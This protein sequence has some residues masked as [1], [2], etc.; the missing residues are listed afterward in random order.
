MEA[1]RFIGM[2][3]IKNEERWIASVIE[4]QLPLVESLLILD[5]NSTDSTRE[6]CRSYD[7]VTL[8]E[9][10]FEGINESRDKEWLL[11]KAYDAI[12]EEDQHYTNGNAESPWFAVCF[13]GDEQLVVDDIPLIREAVQRPGIH[14]LSLRILYLWDSPR[15]WRVDGVYGNF[16]RPSI[17]RLM[18]RAFRYKRT[19][20]GGGANFHCSSIPQELIHH[21]QNPNARCEAR[22]LHWGYFDRDLRLKKFEFYSRVDPNN[23]AEGKYLHVCQGDI[24][25]IPA[26]AKL[27][28][29][30]PLE[31]R[32]L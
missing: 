11:D 14:A 24:P 19:P 18:N 9:S 23:E 20:W 32:P 3:R 22:L 6:I 31:L 30:G 10:P 16:R 15:Q 17:F 21:S 8:F 5:D 4:A 29:A 27:K 12:P 26:H 1:P 25:E 2:M 13:D 28:W 7:K